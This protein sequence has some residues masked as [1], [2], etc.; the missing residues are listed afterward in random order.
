M[1]RLA[2]ARAFFT[3]PAHHPLGADQDLARTTDQVK[4]CVS[5]RER[6]GPAVA[7]YLAVFAAAK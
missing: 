4:D 3:D 5:L 2:A 7:A 6:E 1:E